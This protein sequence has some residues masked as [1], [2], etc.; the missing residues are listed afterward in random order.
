MAPRAIRADSDFEE[1]VSDARP[2]EEVEQ[3]LKISVEATDKG[4]E[5]DGGRAKAPRWTELR[6]ATTWALLRRAPWLPLRGSSTSGASRRVDNCDE[7]PRP[8][9]AP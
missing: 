6:I 5:L 9:P 3:A 8:R 1:G 7:A 4:V 2:R